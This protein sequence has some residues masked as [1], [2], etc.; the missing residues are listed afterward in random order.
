MNENGSVKLPVEFIPRILTAGRYYHQDKA[1]LRKYYTQDSFSLHLYD[2]P[3]TIRIGKLIF[4]F[5]PGAMTIIPRFTEY[6]YDLVRPGY[7]Y[8]IHFRVE[9]LDCGM[10][11]LEVPLFCQMENN[12]EYEL[13]KA[14]L[15]EL[16]E[17]HSLKE[18]NR[19]AA[20]AAKATLVQMFCRL[21]IKRSN[22]AR[23]I[24]SNSETA[25]SR[26]AAV[27]EA[28]LHS[29]LSIPAIAGQAGL[30]QNYLARLF[31][32]H[33]GMTLTAYQTKKR[34]ELAR[35]LLLNSDIKIKEIAARCGI[36]NSQHFNKLFRKFMGKSPSAMRAGT[37][38]Q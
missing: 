5:R 16:I 13:I 23:T 6:S 9:N 1:F 14:K 29:P 20:S 24:Q 32:E 22:S 8:C 27:I 21:S 25:V 36:P 34:L 26:A 31:K 11:E 7:H 10:H 15:Q 28:N 2:Y 12:I 17:F 19:I 30:S 3:G 37:A 4:R 35:Y 18:N 33:Y 38:K